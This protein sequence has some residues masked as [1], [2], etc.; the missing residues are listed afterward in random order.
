MERFGLRLDGDAAG[1]LGLR[2]GCSGEDLRVRR[3]S[4]YSCL[5]KMMESKQLVQ[6]SVSQ[7][8]MTVTYV[9]QLIQ[10]TKE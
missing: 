9:D 4:C 3:K 8:C 1:P 7:T 2:H 10:K 5:P 6:P